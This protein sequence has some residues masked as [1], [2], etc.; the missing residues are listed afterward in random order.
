MPATGA[1]R[2]YTS[3]TQI[4]ADNSSSSV[5]QL[6]TTD[7]AHK[8]H[9][10]TLAHRTFLT[11]Q[12]HPSLPLLL[13]T[14]DQ[15]SAKAA[16]LARNPSIELNWWIGGSADQ[17]RIAGTAH[18]IPFSPAPGAAAGSG[19]DP[20]LD[21]PGIAAL[22]AAGYDWRSK[23]DE[24]FAVLSPGIRASFAGDVD[25]GTRLPGGYAHMDAWPLRLPAD[26]SEA[27]DEGGEERCP[28]GA[29]ALCAAGD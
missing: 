8:P 10:R 28:G 23:A 16:H 24:L 22:D 17:F 6:A 29:G 18:V 2:W 14:T 26:I 21:C 27:K 15:R 9:V 25:P 11:P 20:D 1:P 5:Y 19:V 4:I 7:A 3:L 12:G 13:T